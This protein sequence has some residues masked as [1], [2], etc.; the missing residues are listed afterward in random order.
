LHT[1][2]NGYFRLWNSAESVFQGLFF[3]TNFYTYWLVFI[4]T[5]L[6][7]IYIW[8]FSRLKNKLKIIFLFTLLILQFSLESHFSNLFN[9]FVRNSHTVY[10][11]DLDKSVMSNNYKTFSWY[12]YDTHHHL[13]QERLSFPSDSIAHME[14]WGEEYD[15]WLPL[16]YIYFGKNMGL[17]KYFEHNYTIKNDTIYTKESIIYSVERINGLKLIL[18]SHFN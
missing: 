7:V 12:T 17:K 16:K 5:F 10:N 9:D 14:V 2:I 3:T 11:A 18:H 6:V 13:G 4:P 15:K 1:L 8:S